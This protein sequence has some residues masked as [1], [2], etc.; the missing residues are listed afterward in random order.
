MNWFNFDLRKLM[1]ILLALSL[2]LISIQVQQKPSPKDE[3]F[4]RPFS[5]IAGTVEA[6]VFGFADE[7][8]STTTLYMN[9]IGIKRENEVLREENQSLR[10][11]LQTYGE[12]KKEN[13]RLQ[14]LFDFRAKSKMEMIAAKVIGH[15]LL[16]SDHSTLR[17]DKGTHH[18]LKAGQAVITTDGVLGHT[19]RTEAFSSYILLLSD[20]YSVVDGIVSRSRARGLVE[21]LGGGE[22]SLQYVEK[23]E[24]VQPGDLIVTS[25]LD[26]IFPKGYP[27]AVAEA[28]ENKPYAVSL[29]VTL[30]PVVDPDRVEEVFIILNAAYEEYPDAKL[31]VAP[32]K[33]EGAPTTEPKPAKGP[34][35]EPRA[36]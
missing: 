13:E 16:F 32:V 9:L 10:A 12:L 26:N 23:S 36:H 21:G 7:I 27:I 11:Q 20:R 3:W 31:T 1:R 33:Q 22:A 14:G 29:K 25:G 17:I 6:A 18:G 15:D 4:D 34:A 8:R 30:K 24:D 2:P 5:F 35:S 28:V 19:F